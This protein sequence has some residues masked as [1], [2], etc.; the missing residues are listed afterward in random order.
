M[1]VRETYPK[2][3]SA[4][5]D[6]LPIDIHAESFPQVNTVRKL[7]GS[8]K[9]KASRQV[10]GCCQVRKGVRRLTRGAEMV[11]EGVEGMPKRCS[12][13][14]GEMQGCSAGCG[15]CLRA[16]ARRDSTWGCRSGQHGTSTNRLENNPQMGETYL[17]R[18]QFSLLAS[19]LSFSLQAS[20]KQL[21]GKLEI[22]PAPI[23]YL[24]FCG[25]SVCL[26]R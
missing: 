25:H 9:S 23:I 8:C 16:W 11:G 10:N 19:P 21:A 12:K 14:Q 5:P 7:I 4:Y 2:Q 18:L 1:K 26:L 3:L 13:G 15:V 24:L 22:V 6:G 17:S 20:H